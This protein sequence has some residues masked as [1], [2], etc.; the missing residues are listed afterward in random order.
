MQHARVSARRECFRYVHGIA[1]THMCAPPRPY[2]DTT[3]KRR[4]HTPASP[5]A[6]A[7]APTRRGTAATGLTSASKGATRCPTSSNNA[8]C[9]HTHTHHA[10][11]ACRAGKSP[12]QARHGGHWA[13]IG[14]QGTDPATD[15]RSCGVLGLLQL[16]G[17]YS[18]DAANALR[19]YRLSRHEVQVGPAGRRGTLHE[20]ACDAYQPS[21]GFHVVRQTRCAPIACRG[22]RCRWGGARA[23]RR[24]TCIH[25]LCETVVPCAGKCP[26]KPAYLCAPAGVPH[27]HRVA[28][29][30]QMGHAGA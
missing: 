30:H 10:P 5:A 19:I 6:Q 17:L 20:V 2:A 29:R 12:D 13:D 1:L 4:L 25:M 3:E 9:T 18:W 15:L 7:R 26:D 11:L 24:V 23:A 27:V 16:Y 28:Q 21:I 8:A 14:F 22:A